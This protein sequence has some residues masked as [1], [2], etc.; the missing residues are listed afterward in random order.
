MNTTDA[1]RNLTTSPTSIARSM[2]LTSTTFSVSKPNVKST[3]I[4]PS[5]SM[6]SLF[7]SNGVPP[8]YRHPNATS[9]FAAGSMVLYISSGMTKN[10]ITPNSKTN[11]N[12]RTHDPDLPTIIPGDDDGGSVPHEQPEL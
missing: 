5:P 8:R 7:N 3:T 6:P 11:P 12:V 4:I 2:A 10:S 1:L 9:S